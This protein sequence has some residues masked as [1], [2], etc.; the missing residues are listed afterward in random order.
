MRMSQIPYFIISKS[1]PCQK[2]YCVTYCEGEDILMYTYGNTG[3]GI[4]GR[5]ENA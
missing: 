4:S 1:F 5:Y 3:G 2:K